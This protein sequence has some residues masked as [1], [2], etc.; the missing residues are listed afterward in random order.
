VL[1]GDVMTIIATTCGLCG[2]EFEPDHRA[3]VAGT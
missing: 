1:G 3:I 2:Q